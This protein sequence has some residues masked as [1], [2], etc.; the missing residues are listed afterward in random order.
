MTQFY[1]EPK[2][3]IGGGI[4]GDISDSHTCALESAGGLVK[5]QMTVPLPAE[6][7]IEE[8]RPG[9]QEFKFLTSSWELVMLLVGDP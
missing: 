2:E 5:A 4:V 6:S 8:V 1:T 9:V 3:K 7:L